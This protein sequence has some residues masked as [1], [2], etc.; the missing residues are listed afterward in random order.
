M[1]KRYTKKK[2]KKGKKGVK[3]EKELDMKGYMEKHK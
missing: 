3:E 2:A 1:A